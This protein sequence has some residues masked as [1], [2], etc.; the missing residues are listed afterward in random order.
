MI[1]FKW[2]YDRKIKPTKKGFQIN[3]SL[4]YIV[5][6]NPAHLCLNNI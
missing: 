5:S 4:F 2:E 6:F 1:L 3:E